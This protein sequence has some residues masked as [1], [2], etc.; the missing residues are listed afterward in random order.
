MRNLYRMIICPN[1]ILLKFS[2]K[3]K[4][5]C[6][7]RTKANAPRYHLD[8]LIAQRALR[9]AITGPCCNGHSRAVLQGQR[10]F[11]GMISR[12][13]SATFCCG[14]FQPSTSVS[15]SA[16]AAYSSWSEV[17][18]PPRHGERKGFRGV[19]NGGGIHHRHRHLRQAVSPPVSKNTRGASGRRARGPNGVQ[20]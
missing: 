13:H 14:G 11:F 16:S 8:S 17:I 19:F 9:P 4:S 12:R 10:P 6:P 7:M 1:I 20:V 2:L 15:I 18:I 3:T 5:P